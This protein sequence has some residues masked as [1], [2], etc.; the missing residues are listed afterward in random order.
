MPRH[1][2]RE[3][4]ASSLPEKAL[5]LDNGAFTLKAGFAAEGLTEADCHVI[6]NCIARGADGRRGNKIYIADQLDDCKDFAEMT[7]RR[8]V[9]K[10]FIV[11]WETQLDIWKQ[12]FFDEGAKL[13]VS[14]IADR[15]RAP[16]CKS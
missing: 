2:K 4:A 6:P 11:N 16:S 13:H 5:V 3:E 12:V 10:G 8:P 1:P 9:E 14:S 15:A 7:F